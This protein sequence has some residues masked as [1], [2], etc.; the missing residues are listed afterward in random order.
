MCEWGVCHVQQHSFRLIYTNNSVKCQSH[1]KTKAKK[2]SQMYVSLKRLP[3]QAVT[4]HCYGCV[5][6]LPLVAQQCSA[7]SGV[8][9]HCC[10]RVPCATGLAA[11]QVAVA[12]TCSSAQG[13]LS[14]TVKL[15]LDI[16]HSV[17]TFIFCIVDLVQI[18]CQC[19]CLIKGSI[20][21]S[22]IA[23]LLVALCGSGGSWMKSD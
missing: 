13:C 1:T 23:L 4:V 17:S 21:N 14:T 22:W 11:V 6:Y 15:R 19:M 12:M 10:G 16:W 18:Q 8:T 20:T 2:P 7:R 9:A 3:S 5:F